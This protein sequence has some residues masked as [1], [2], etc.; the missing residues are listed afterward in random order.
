MNFANQT[1]GS[2]NISKLKDLNKFLLQ[3]SIKCSFGSVAASI[4]YKYIQSLGA[5]G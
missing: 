2:N 4:Y 3:A 1:S 5:W